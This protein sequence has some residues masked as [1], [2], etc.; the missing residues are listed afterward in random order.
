MQACWSYLT[1][2]VAYKAHFYKT[3]THW[4]KTFVFFWTSVFSINCCIL[5]GFGSPVV[6]ECF[7]K[8]GKAEPGNIIDA[9]LITTL[10]RFSSC[11]GDVDAAPP[12]SD[13]SP[14]CSE[15]LTSSLYTSESILTMH[16][17]EDFSSD[18]NHDVF[19]WKRNAS[20]A[21]LSWP[22]TLNIP[23]ISLLPN[24]WLRTSM[25]LFPGSYAPFH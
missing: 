5:V 18:D 7:Y 20:L 8:S 22:F 2:G 10:I 12:G 17:A 23:P 9:A 11:S 6:L 16:S 24:I 4:C 15:V 21:P 25:S 3:Y 14:P 19:L 13:C 1:F